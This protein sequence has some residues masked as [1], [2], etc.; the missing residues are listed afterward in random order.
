[1]ETT[2]L[3]ALLN[4]LKKKVSSVEAQ[5]GDTGPQGPQGAVG[6]KGERGPKGDTGPQGP[7][8]AVGA[9]GKQGPKG[10]K[11]D[12]GIGVESVSMAADGDLV[13][14]LSDGTEE[15]VE[16]PEDLLRGS[17]RDSGSTYIVKQES[18][19]KAPKDVFVSDTQPTT[20]TDQYLWIQTGLGDDGTGFTAWFNDPNFH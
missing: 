19:A 11:G 15:V 20:E 10:D 16:L 2:T 6:A 18:N 12:D 8:G 5:K 9:K 3:L 13:F 1:V 7:Q 14:T 4:D 17:Q